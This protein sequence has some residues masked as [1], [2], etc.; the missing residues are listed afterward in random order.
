MS[1]A[2]RLYSEK[3]L[4]DPIPPKMCDELTPWLS[5]LFSAVVIL[6]RDINFTWI[7]ASIWLV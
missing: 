5:G 2:T 6:S 1:N 4:Q 3:E 7:F